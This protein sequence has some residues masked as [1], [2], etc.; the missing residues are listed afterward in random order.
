MA[1]S[2]RIVVFLIAL[3]VAGGM[4]AITNEA[5]NEMEQPISDGTDTD[6]TQKIHKWVGQFWFFTPVFLVVAG[7]VWLIKQS[8]VVSG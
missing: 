4:F 7:G 2:W 1:V 5:I 6:E 8:V 3:L